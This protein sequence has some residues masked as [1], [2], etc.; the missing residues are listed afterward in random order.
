MEEIKNDKRKKKYAEYQLEWLKDHG[1][2]LEDLVQEMVN[3]LL[4]EAP[5]DLE[6]GSIF[7]I[8]SIIRGCFDNLDFNGELWSCYDEWLNNEDIEK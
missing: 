8:A 6:C 3:C 4:E 7:D 5:E 1:Y 2:G